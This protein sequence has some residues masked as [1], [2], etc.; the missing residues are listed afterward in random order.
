MKSFIAILEITVASLIMG[1]CTSLGH[2]DRTQ[3][4]IEVPLAASPQIVA[5]TGS[6]ELS[7]A[8]ELLLASRGVDVLLSPLQ[9]DLKMSTQKDKVNKPVRYAIN[10]TSVDQ[11]MCVPEGSRQMHFHISVVDLMENKRVYAMSGDYGCKNTIVK[12][13]EKWLFQ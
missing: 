4:Q 2:E 5:F 13:F 10:A 11:D 12:R 6:G 7:I 9:I 3:P 8:I 1:G